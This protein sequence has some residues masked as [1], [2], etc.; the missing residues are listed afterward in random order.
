MSSKYK[1]DL[2]IYGMNPIILFRASLA[3]ESEI[4][5]ASK[6]FE[7]QMFRSDIPADSLVFG[8]YSVLPFYE[9]VECPMHKISNDRTVFRTDQH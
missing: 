8:R 3:E 9:W 1:T 4:S 2:Y 7:I 6:Y 5:A